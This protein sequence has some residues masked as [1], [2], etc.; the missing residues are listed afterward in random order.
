MG[1][2]AKG[3]V[4]LLTIAALAPAQVAAQQTVVQDDEWC[5][6][7][8]SHGDMER[9][10]EVRETTFRATGGTIDVLARPNGGIKVEGWDRNEIRV[11]ALV[12][13]WA[14]SE[15]DARRL[16]GQVEVKASGS[17]ISSSG[18]K[19][20]WDEE[21]W[22]V[23]FRVNVP[24]SSD[25]DLAT[26]NGGITIDGVSGKIRFETTNGGVTIDELGGDVRGS[27]TNGGLTVR[28]GGNTWQGSGLDVETT[29]GGVTMRIPE[30]YS[31]RLETGTVN[32]GLS[33]DFPITVQG[34]IDRRITTDLGDGGP[35]IRARTTNGGVRIEKS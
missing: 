32:G 11:R 35:T 8:G 26:T 16:M 7:S 24:R 21:H 15:D 4:A 13:A 34:R 10:C 20:D 17:E 3:A 14:E 22:V 2:W 5:D 6:Q 30:G 18:P 28:L 19:T 29:N 1:G 31:A 33:I 27:T 9:T 12:Q 23:S 25:L